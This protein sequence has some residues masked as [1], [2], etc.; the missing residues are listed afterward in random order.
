[1]SRV[2]GY[3]FPGYRPGLCLGCA[4][5]FV[6][7]HG[8]A[9]PRLVVGFADDE[10]PGQF[11]N[12]YRPV[13]LVAQRHATWLNVIV[14]VGYLECRPADALAPYVDCGWVRSNIAGGSL[15]VMPDGCVDVFVTGEG[16]VMVSGPATTFY[17]QCASTEGVLIGL[18]LRPGAAA[19]VLG[20][21]VSELRDT[22]IR[23]DSVFGTSAAGLAEDVLAANAFRQRVALLE[24]VLARYLVK[25][26]PVVDQ[27]VAR[28]IE[29]L[30][31]HPPRCVSDVASRVGLS[32]R[33]LRRRFDAAVG[34]GPK[35]LGRIFRFQRLLD[36]IHSDDHRIRWAEL[37]IEAGYADQSHLINECL[38]LAGAVPTA[39]PGAGG[40][41]PA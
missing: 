6:G 16:A 10:Q 38:A 22:Q 21:P 2:V 1:M 17:D 18:R 26:D 4:S 40:P 7:L 9:A 25:V 5:S 24:A 27:P 11:T 41:P 32:E 33:Q 20:H 36:L 8:V 39:L 35:R 29:M 12:D 37:A 15:R 30:R 3:R 28:S 19:A 13:G 34:F 31:I 23:I 14:M